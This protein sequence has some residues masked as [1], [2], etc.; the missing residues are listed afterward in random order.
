MPRRSEGVRLWLR[1]GKGGRGPVW[2]IRDGGN[3]KSTG[4]GE[5]DRGAAE[6]QLAEYILE[7]HTVSRDRNR[8]SDEIAVADVIAIYLTDV[9]PK[10]ARPKETAQRAGALL[11]WWG[12]KTLSEVTGANCRAYTASREG[13]QW[14]AA[15][16]V[17]KAVSGA[18][19]R[20]ELEDLRAAIN[21]HRK[22]GLCRHV[23]E[24][25]LPPKP[26]AREAWLS[27]D[28]AARLIW[29][30]WRS[31]DALTKRWLGRHTAR[32]I[33]VAL[34]TGTRSSA[35]CGAA[36]RPTVGRAYVD[37]ER[38]VFHRKPSRSRETKKRRPPARLSSR[39][40]AHLRRWERTGLSSAYVVEWNGKAVSSIR[41]GFS[42]ARA[43]AGLEPAITP[44]ILRHT[45]ATWLM[46]AGA[47]LW[48]AAGL[49]GMTTEQLERTYGH[50]HPDFQKDAA[51]QLSGRT[52]FRHRNP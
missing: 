25:T 9:A 38:G 16:K 35:V 13:Q 2:V 51:E 20:R 10:H 46:Q 47:D 12:D 48:E 1:K 30:A 37:L 49:L 29:A 32:F 26:M 22:E 17:E 44:H 18:A 8:S 42:S 11:D 43:K 19:P 15:K 41:K 3:W 21:Y 39:L 14:K 45:A 24:V 33:L 7:R 6:K 28:E 4:C 40:L 52:Q 36:I 31:R 27:R 23:V 34:Y 5:A 50:H